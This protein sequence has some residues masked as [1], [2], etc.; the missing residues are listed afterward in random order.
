MQPITLPVGII[1]PLWLGHHSW[2]QVAAGSLH[3]QLHVGDGFD[4]PGDFPG[5]ACTVSRPPFYSTRLIY[6]PLCPPVIQ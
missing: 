4:D 1:D 6:E 5:D 2:V 3:Q